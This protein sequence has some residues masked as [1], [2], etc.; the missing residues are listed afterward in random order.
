MKRL[1]CGIFVCLLMIVC[2]SCSTEGKFL[3]EWCTDA[4]LVLIKDEVS[5]KKTDYT[6]YGPDEIK[7][8]NYEIQVPYRIDGS[9]GIDLEEIPVRYELYE[10]VSEGT[11]EMARHVNRDAVL[12]DVME[13]SFTVKRDTK[14]GVL[15]VK[16]D[17]NAMSM[18]YGPD[19]YAYIWLSIQLMDDDETN[20]CF[21]IHNPFYRDDFPL[22]DYADFEPLVTDIELGIAF[23][24]ISLEKQ[25]KLNGVQHYS[26]T[27]P[28]KVEDAGKI[29]GEEIQVGADFFYI[30]TWYSMGEGYFASVLFQEGFSL[31]LRG[32]V[33][34]E[35][36]QEQYVATVDMYNLFAGDDIGETGDDIDCYPY[37]WVALGVR[38]KNMNNDFY[39]I[40]NPYFDSM[41]N[42]EPDMDTWRIYDY[43]RRSNDK[44]EKILR[45]N[46]EWDDG[47]NRKQND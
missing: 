16:T 5:V 40:K 20:N 34:I 8:Q 12:Y 27:I 44:I 43:A 4:D 41:K 13:A 7:Y 3:G 39:F 45:A 32:S 10:N 42:E 11:T 28:I 9:L 26:L 19:S 6:K 38:D 14:E 17:Y 31:G 15:T 33:R 21:F 23:E 1:L 2:C 22:A 37:F 47:W 35:E 25:E 29:Q 46:G 18:K 24:D 30:D 36:V